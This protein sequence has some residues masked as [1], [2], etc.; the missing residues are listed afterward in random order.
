MLSSVLSKEDCAECR[1]CCSFR[2]ISLWET[3][4]FDSETADKL[5]E[6]FPDAKFKPCRGVLTIDI[7]N[8][9]TTDDPSEEALCPFN[10]NGCVL[11]NSLKPFDCMIWPLR[12][13]RTEG[14]IAICL[15]PTCPVISGKP[16]GVMKALADS[17]TGDKIFSYAS[18]HPE[19]IMDHR[20]GYEILRIKKED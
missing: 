11:D 10:R 16:V 6:R 4:L 7:D 18:A 9:Y 15:T 8:N 2:R 1:F 14:G 19:M 13:M 5:R 3:P 12:V 17:D 20:E